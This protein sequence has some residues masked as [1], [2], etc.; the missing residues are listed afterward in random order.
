MTSKFNY[1]YK[2]IFGSI[3]FLFFILYTIEKYFLSTG[4]DL[5]KTFEIILLLAIYPIFLEFKK[6]LPKIKKIFT[7]LIYEIKKDSSFLAKLSEGKI[8][9]KIVLFPLISLSLWRIFG[10]KI[11][12]LI[13]IF[14]GGVI[15]IHILSSSRENNTAILILGLFWIISVFFSKLSGEASII[16]GGILLL[17]SPLV[18]YSK[19]VLISEK[20]AI[21]AYIFLVV[22]SMQLIF[23]HLKKSS[24]NEIDQ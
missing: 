15:L 5:R 8:G 13:P 9:G 2:K 6:K 22:G 3:V 1:Y 24:K 11:L 23:V 7:T 12:Y 17:I 21:W 16:L 4:L 18:N 19:Q 10:K 14:T 20:T